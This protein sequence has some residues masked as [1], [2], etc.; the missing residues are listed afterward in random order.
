MHG[1]VPYST[2]KHSM[3]IL[4]LTDY[5]FQILPPMKVAQT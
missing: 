5:V 2:H 1:L 4:I 3:N